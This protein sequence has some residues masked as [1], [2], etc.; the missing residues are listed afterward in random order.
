MKGGVGKTTLVAGIASSLA[1]KLGRERVWVV[2]LDPKNMLCW[3]LGLGV[4][5]LPASKALGA[6]HLDESFAEARAHFRMSESGVLCLAFGHSTEAQRKSF[7]ARLAR[8]PGWLGKLL[9]MAGAGQDSLVIVDTPPGPS[10]YQKQA[11]QAAHLGV[12]VTLADAASFATMASMESSFSNHLR[13]TRHRA[14]VVNQF[15]QRLGLGVDVVN[16][17]RQQLGEYLSPLLVNQDEGVREALALQ[18]TSLQYDPHCRASH[19][20][21]QLGQWLIQRLNRIESE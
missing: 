15:D 2:D 11:L 1:K 9:Q 4:Q 6:C 5:S 10:L 13:Q 3:H 20:I 7:E 19:D 14:Y 17:L 21:D 18:Q 16:M 12:A 8:Q